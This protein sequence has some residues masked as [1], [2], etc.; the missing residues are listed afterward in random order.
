MVGEIGE[1]LA[2][3]VIGDIQ[4]AYQRG[5]LIITEDCIKDMTKFGLYGQDLQKVILSAATIA[6]V[7]PTSS[8]RASNPKNTHYVIYG[9][10]TSGVL[11]YCK[12]CTNYHPI[13]DDFIC[14]R[15]TSFC[16]SD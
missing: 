10:S 4:G 8:P 11:V 5:E 16:H 14:W 12:V 1:Q 9:E 13:T 7:M 3:L 6:K 2:P 15:L